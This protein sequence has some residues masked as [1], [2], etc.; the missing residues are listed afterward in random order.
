MI[1]GI[2]S[3]SFSSIFLASPLAYLV[4]KRSGKKN[5]TTK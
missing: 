1:F 5:L 4:M 3:G 2:I